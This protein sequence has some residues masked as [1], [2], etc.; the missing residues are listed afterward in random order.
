MGV[1]FSFVGLA[2]LVGTPIEGTLVRIGDGPYVW[3]R[4]IIFCGVSARAWSSQDDITLLTRTS[5]VMVL[6][7]ALGMTL[8]RH[9]F[10][11]Q[12]RG[13]ERGLRV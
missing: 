7:G 5:K 6:G 13:G 3:Y 11:R 1:A 2:L 4:A 10:I 8:S 12:G 9:V